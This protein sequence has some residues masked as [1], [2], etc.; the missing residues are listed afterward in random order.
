[1]QDPK[2]T[3]VT[4][5]RCDVRD[6]VVIHKLLESQGVKT[7]NIASL[8]RESLSLLATLANQHGMAPTVISTK[9]ALEYMED[10]FN[11]NPVSNAYARRNIAKALTLEKKSH[12]SALTQEQKDILLERF[13]KL[14]EEETKPQ[15]P[16]RSVRVPSNVNIVDEE[17]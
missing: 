2:N 7:T 1:M 9:E 4:T 11:Y 17:D 14:E 13:K 3:F 15:G 5:I 16:A 8:L 10:H 12:G 6:L